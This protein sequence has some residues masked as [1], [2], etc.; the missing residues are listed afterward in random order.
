M[1]YTLV[2]LLVGILVCG[3]ESLQNKTPFPTT[4][5]PS[6]FP[7]VLD[8]FISPTR[9][10]PGTPWNSDL[11][12]IEKP[13]PKLCMVIIIPPSAMSIVYSNWTGNRE[14]CHRE[15]EYDS[16]CGYSMYS[17]VL[18]KCIKSTRIEMRDSSKEIEKYTS[19]KWSVARKKTVPLRYF[20][21]YCETFGKKSCN[22]NKECSW[23]KG[24][25]GYNQQHIE[26]DGYC[27]RIKC[28]K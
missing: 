1:K 24:L 12:I 10:R 6:Q 11:F 23:N 28:I 8:T 5:Y 20:N 19:E 17:N 21:T 4:P 16:L 15:C 27:G 18:D 25:E 26:F 2:S 3:V 22:K 14:Q 7:T 13:N 9:I